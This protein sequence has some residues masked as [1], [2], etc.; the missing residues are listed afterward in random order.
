MSRRLLAG[1][2]TTNANKRN[3]LL[4]DSPRG[5]LVDFSAAQD[6]INILF[7]FCTT[8]AAYP[9]RSVVGSVDRGT[10]VLNLCLTE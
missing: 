4:L 7:T 1:I 2:R 6:A 9:A 5:W 10:V 8:K 3:L